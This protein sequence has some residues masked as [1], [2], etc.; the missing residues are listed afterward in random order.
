MQV[1]DSFFPVGAFSYSDG[2]E[3]AVSEGLITDGATLQ[4]WLERWCEYSFRDFE[5]LGLIYQ[6]TAWHDRDWNQLRETDQEITALQPSSFT[7][8]SSRTLGK[9]LLRTCIPIYPDQGLELLLEQIENNSLRGNAVTVYAALFD[10]MGLDAHQALLSYAYMRLASMISAALRLIS[11]GQQEGQQ[12]LS[13]Q[14][15]TVPGLVEAI[16]QSK[17][18]PLMMFNPALDICQMNHRFLYSRLF[19]S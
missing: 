10:V 18:A 14:L 3:S 8:S 12:R 9:R 15:E 7:R 16:I 5:G 1:C 4:E 6:M 2:L 13:R 11:I 19:R 17:G